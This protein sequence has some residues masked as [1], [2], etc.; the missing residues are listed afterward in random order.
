MMAD[1]GQWWPMMTY[2]GSWWLMMVDNG[3]ECLIIISCQSLFTVRIIINSVI[4]H[5]QGFNMLQSWQSIM[6]ISQH[7]SKKNLH[8]HWVT[9]SLLVASHHRVPPRNS[10][11]RL[12]GGEPPP[13]PAPPWLAWYR[14]SGASPS[15]LR[16]PRMWWC[17]WWVNHRSANDGEWYIHGEWTS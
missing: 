11:H 12:P 3:Q 4:N 13:W 1:D 7:N 6:T 14:K 15:L 2:G 10:H 16:W 5:S 17:S 8:Y 9:G